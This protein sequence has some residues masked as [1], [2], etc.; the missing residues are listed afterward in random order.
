M[1]L[2]SIE[3]MVDYHFNTMRYDIYL[4]W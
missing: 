1:T 3:L 4:H 2:S